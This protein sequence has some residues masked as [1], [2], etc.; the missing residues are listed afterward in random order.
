MKPW[1]SLSGDDDGKHYLLYPQ[2]EDKEDWNYDIETIIDTGEFF[3]NVFICYSTAAYSFLV[4]Y[5][6]N[7]ETPIKIKQA[8][9]NNF[10]ACFVNN[11]I[12]SL[13]ES[14]FRINALKTILQR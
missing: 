14:F 7:S 12:H 1:I 13:N 8:L 3:S 5:F 2:S 9:R 10:D 11:N 6:R 4:Y